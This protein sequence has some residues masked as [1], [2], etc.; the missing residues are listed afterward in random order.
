MGTLTSNLGSLLF[1]Y[2]TKLYVPAHNIL[3]GTILSLIIR[4][5]P[6]CASSYPLPHFF[7][8]FSGLKTHMDDSFSHASYKD[9]FI[10]LILLTCRHVHILSQSYPH[11]FQQT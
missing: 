9:G 5:F 6:A 1:A 4:D 3:L 7:Q 11:C 8:A 2:F 10:F